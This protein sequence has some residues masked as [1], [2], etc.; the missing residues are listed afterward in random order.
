MN[1]STP[2]QRPHRVAFRL[3][4]VLLTLSMGILALKLRAILVFAL[5]SEEEKRLLEVSK[6][7]PTISDL[8]QSAHPALNEHLGSLNLSRSSKLEESILGFLGMNNTIYLQEPGHQR[9]GHKYV[10]DPL[11]GWRNIPGWKASTLGRSITINSKGLRDKEYGYEKKSDTNRILVLGDSFSWGYGVSNEE[12]FTEVLERTLAKCT[13]PVEVINSGVSGWGTD[14][15]YLFLIS[16]G[17]RYSPD[18]IVLALYLAND[19]ENNSKSKQYG[20]HKPY[21][22][23]A[24][25]DLKNVPVP[26]PDE[27]SAPFENSRGLRITAAL[28]DKMAKF[29]RSIES[30]LVVMTFGSRTD[31]RFRKLKQMLMQSVSVDSLFYLDLDLELDN[32]AIT[33]EEMLKGNDDGHWNAWGHSQVSQI[34]LSFLKQKRLMAF[35]GLPQTP[36]A[37]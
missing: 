29:S 19:L 16:E 10:Y 5:M 28:I 23:D 35:D 20:L 3:A 15:E 12:I 11:L 37:N 22:V 36:V 21:F 17:Y 26:F 8:Y 9:T 4:S 1:D 14:Q 31:N 7:L 32:R 27:K 13:S 18:L 2:I 33:E 24:S 6:N 30:D 34:L 25:L